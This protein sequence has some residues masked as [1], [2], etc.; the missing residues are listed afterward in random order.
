MIK[1]LQSRKQMSN[2]EIIQAKH[3]RCKS[4][5]MK[6]IASMLVEYIDEKYSSLAEWD[7]LYLDTSSYFDYLTLPLLNENEIFNL[8]QFLESCFDEKEKHSQFK[9]LLNKI[10]V[11]EDVAEIVI[12][13]KRLNEEY[14]LKVS[15][16]DMKMQVCIFYFRQMQQL[17]V[18]HSQIIKW[19]FAEF[20]AKTKQMKFGIIKTDLPETSLIKIMQVRCNSKLNLLNCICLLQKKDTAI[21][22]L[23]YF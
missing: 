5:A 21:A 8:N 14:L 12:L 15:Q 19:N 11:F 7:E 4:L 18:L 9:E 16:F 23:K 1:F 10:T 22:N 3:N 2:L 13:L 17:K 6:A 20:E